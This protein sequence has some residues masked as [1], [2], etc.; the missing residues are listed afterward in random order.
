L[1]R[2]KGSS[3]QIGKK[4]GSSANLADLQGTTVLTR[5][6]GSSLQIGKKNGATITPKQTSG[7]FLITVVMSSITID[8]HSGYGRFELKQNGTT[9]EIFGY[10]FGWSS[11]DNDKG[12]R[13]LNK[14]VT[15]STGSSFTFDA[16][17]IGNGSQAVQVNRDSRG[18]SSVTIME[19]AQ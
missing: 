7:T 16:H 11:T 12:D 9:I 5:K 2:K 19:I 15:F 18:W 13:T 6:K 4:K 1:T 17:Y 10:P 3:L 14:M 8:V